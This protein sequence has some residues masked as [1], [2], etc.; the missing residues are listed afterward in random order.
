MSETYPDMHPDVQA[1]LDAARDL[2]NRIADLRERIDAVRSRQPSPSGDA[3]AE[4]DAMGR[5]T[6]LYLAPGAVERHP[7]PALAAEIMASIT[8]STDDASHLYHGIMNE[9]EDYDT[10][11]D[12]KTD[13][14]EPVVSDSLR[15]TEADQ[16]DTDLDAP[17]VGDSRWSTDTDQA[18]TDP[19]APVVGDSRWSTETNRQEAP[20]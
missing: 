10:P 1:A 16:A 19:D 7:G 20:S 13:P 8:A 4:V 17:I 12:A 6:N 11:A 9:P 14:D 2:R 15:S 18:D 3:I 5:L